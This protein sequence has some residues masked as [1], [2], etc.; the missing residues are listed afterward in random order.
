MKSA[1]KKVLKRT[2]FIICLLSLLPVNA[3][4]MAQEQPLTP[5][6]ILDKV[7]DLF[8]S[9]SSH[10]FATMTVATAHWKRS[11]SLEM[12]SKGKEKS[13]VRILAPKKEKGTATLRSG[14]DIWNYLPKVKRVIKLPSSMMAASWMGSH[15]TNDDL[16][17]E[18]RMAEDY[19]FEITFMGEDDG[20][21]IVEVTCH[22]KPEAAVVWGRVLVRAR[23]KDYLPLFVKY[24]DEDLRLARTM[25]FSRV[26]ELGGRLI[27]AMVTMVPEEKPEES[28][29]INYENMEFDIGLEDD[30]FSLRTLQR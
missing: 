18:S 2:F 26:A 8:R 11:L 23:M 21:K 24:F 10:G 20:E 28:T 27:P 16:V 13:L 29:K 5:K 14:N 9:Q 17:K 7:D 12:W 6:Q 1:I 3:P 19:T 25:T 15:F 30:F 4:L 22:P